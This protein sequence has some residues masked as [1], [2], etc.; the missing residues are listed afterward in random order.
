MTLLGLVITRQRKYELNLDH[1]ISVGVEVVK[2][3]TGFLSITLSQTAAESP[4]C[5]HFAVCIL[6]H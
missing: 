5:H 4:F 2:V 3:C 6:E 1:Q